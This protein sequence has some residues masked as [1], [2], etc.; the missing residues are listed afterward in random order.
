VLLKASTSEAP[1]DFASLV[2]VAKQAL[3]LDDLEMSRLLKVSRPTV[4][5]WIRAESRPH[6]LVRRAICDVLAKSARVRL[7]LLKAD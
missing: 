7:K 3:L 1:H 5:R 4:G 6:E 2:I